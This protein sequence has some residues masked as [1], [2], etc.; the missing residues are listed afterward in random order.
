[1]AEDETSSGLKVVVLRKASRE[2]KDG[3][4][5][6]MPDEVASAGT[7]VSLHNPG[8]PLQAL[9]EAVA[10]ADP[11]DEPRVKAIREALGSGDYGV[12]AAAIAEKLTAMEKDL[13]EVPPTTPDP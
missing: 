9:A 10:T 1:M 12:D 4:V 6:P 3:P 2:E 7:V 13:P 5:S 8:S 11:V